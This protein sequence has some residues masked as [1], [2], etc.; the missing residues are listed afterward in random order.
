MLRILNHYYC[1]LISIHF[2]IDKIIMMSP[3]IGILVVLILVF[4]VISSSKISL[5]V[6]NQRVNI[7][8]TLQGSDRN[9]NNLN[10]GN[11]EGTNKSVSNGIMNILNQ[12]KY[13][14]L[15]MAAI[16]YIL[17]QIS[18]EIGVLVLI[19][20]LIK[21]KEL[22]NG[23]NDLMDGTIDRE[24]Q[25]HKQQ[26]IN[27]NGSDELNNNDNYDKNYYEGNSQQYE[28]MI[29][30]MHPNENQYQAPNVIDKRFDTNFT[31]DPSKYTGKP[32][33]E[34][35]KIAI[36]PQY[37]DFKSSTITHQAYDPS[38]PNP[39]PKIDEEEDKMDEL[40]DKLE[41]DN[42]EEGFI[43]QDTRFTNSSNINGYGSSLNDN[44]VPVQSNSNNSKFTQDL[45]SSNFDYN[46]KMD[47]DTETA[48]NSLS[49]NPSNIQMSISKVNQS[50]GYDTDDDIDNLFRDLDKAM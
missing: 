9:N 49:P 43:A 50:S 24:S 15:T 25:I 48:F 8:E 36:R 26:M 34:K 18:I 3:N 12:Y 41:N 47:L 17:F 33:F 44:S 28:H 22:S 4:L 11:S 27:N 1:R 16:G 32:E 14:L 7:T 31:N 20:M 37:D 30:G 5:N 21:H 19:V 42:N 2:N 46:P 23:L 6:G 10:L 29:G 38:I 39:E 45:R 35:Q 40:F 13:L